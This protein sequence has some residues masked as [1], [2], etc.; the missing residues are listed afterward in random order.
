MATA[1]SPLPP[2]KRGLANIKQDLM[3]DLSREVAQI[4]PFDEKLHPDGLIDITSSVNALM[5]KDLEKYMKAKIPVDFKTGMHTP[6]I[7]EEQY[8]LTLPHPALPY[9]ATAGSDG[10]L[11][12]VAGFINHHFHPSAPILPSHV[13]V[14]NGVT[15]LLDFLPFAI[16]DP[17]DGIMYTTPVYGMFPH[18][19]NS[20]NDIQI[21]PVTCPDGF[22]QF[23]ASNASTLIAM[24]DSELQRAKERGIMTKCVLICNPCNP[25]GRAYS[26]ET[27]VALARWCAREGLHLVSDEIY[28]MSVFPSRDGE[29][30]GFTSVLSIAEQACIDGRNI[31]VLYG[32]SKDFGLGGLRLGFL[33]TRNE[34]LK[35]AVRRLW[36]CYPF[37]TSSSPC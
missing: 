26:R 9:G 35:E 31:H 13:L 32:A 17:G 2:S 7:R 20:R 24:F 16:C 1:T 36:L 21:I 27:L 4:P 25:L 29:L 11:K 22:D 18:D 10:L 33:V 23:K 30:D 6:H 3:L 8:I 19:M 34:N 15:P 12:A 37:L 28:A 14:T 5:L